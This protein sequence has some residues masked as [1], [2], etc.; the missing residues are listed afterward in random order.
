MFFDSWPSLGHTALSALCAYVALI[1]FLR[2]GGKRTLAKMNA[3]D[4]VVTIALGSTLASVIT[5]KTLPLADGLLALAMLIAL[6]YG[7][8]SAII[9]AHWFQRLVKSRPRSVFRDRR[10]DEEAMRRE[11]LARD[12]VLMAMRRAGIHDVDSVYMVVLES[13]GSLSVLRHP[14][15][16]PAR[17]TTTDVAGR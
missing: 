4:F 7:V 6:Q 17:P 9:R 5:S 2:V 10:F 13:D 1:V 15:E 16:D 3:F 14:E 8:A 11:R 12:E